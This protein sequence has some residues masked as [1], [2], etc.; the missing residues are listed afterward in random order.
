M[1]GKLEIKYLANYV[2][3]LA[4]L[5]RSYLSFLLSVTRVWSPDQ[6]YTSVCVALV[7]P[8]LKIVSF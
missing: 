4:I 5:E 1:H 8:I 3:C 6:M 2:I 7:I